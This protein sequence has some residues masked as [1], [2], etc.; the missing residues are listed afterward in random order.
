[1]DKIKNLIRVFNSKRGYWKNPRD[2]A[3]TIIKFRLLSGHND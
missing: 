2:V 1:M 3:R